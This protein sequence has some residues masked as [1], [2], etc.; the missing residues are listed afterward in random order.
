MKFYFSS[1]IFTTIVTVVLCLSIIE[2]KNSFRSE[3]NDKSLFI[4]N[5]AIKNKNY[6]NNNNR[7]AY[8]NKS[9]IKYLAKKVSLKNSKF[10][11]INTTYNKS[12]AQ[13]SSLDNEYINNENNNSVDVHNT[14]HKGDI[15]IIYDISNSLTNFISKTVKKIKE[16]TTK[17]KRKKNKTSNYRIKHRTAYDKSQYLPYVN[18]QPN[19]KFKPIKIRYVH[20]DS[21]LEKNKQNSEFDEPTYTKYFQDIINPVKIYLE[22]FLKVYPLELVKN[23]D[24]TQKCSH[25]FKDDKNKIREFDVELNKYLENGKY[26]SSL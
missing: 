9:S 5:I 25:K 3:L 2:S 10:R 4:T 22:K 6:M 20:V 23:M 7:N 17:S 18:N 13:K 15:N 8:K 24:N 19:E 14:N 11:N 16:H 21:D 1:L 26:V 12:Y